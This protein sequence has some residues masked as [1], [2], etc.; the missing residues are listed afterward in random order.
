[1]IFRVIRRKLDKAL[2]YFTSRFILAVIK[3][4]DSFHISVVQLFICR[5]RRL[6]LLISF[7]A[8]IGFGQNSNSRN[9]AVPASGLSVH[10]LE[11][12]GS[13][14]HHIV[15]LLCSVFYL[16]SDFIYSKTEL[17]RE[18]HHCHIK[19]C[20]IDEIA[21]CVIQKF[22]RSIAQLYRTAARVEQPVGSEPFAALEFFGILV[23]EI[24][25]AFVVP[26]I[27]HEY[28][29]ILFEYVAERL[30]PLLG[31]L[32]YGRLV[33]LGIHQQIV[34][35]LDYRGTLSRRG[36]VVRHRLMPYDEGELV[37]IVIYSILYEMIEIG[38]YDNIVFRLAHY[39]RKRDIAHRGAFIHHNLLK[40]FVALARLLVS[41][42]IIVA[43]IAV[44]VLLGDALVGFPPLKL[45]ITAAFRYLLFPSV[46]KLL[47]GWYPR[48]YGRARAYNKAK[49]LVAVGSLRHIYIIHKRTYPDYL[50]ILFSFSSFHC[51]LP[52]YKDSP[53]LYIISHAL[54]SPE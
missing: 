43:V 26:G 48:R 15:L 52:Q 44:L 34:M 37:L 4:H 16:L 19:V 5:N 35:Y 33:I 30:P 3:I 32:I 12:L 29:M 22:V 27:A 7:F 10:L 47:P 51:R 1:M 18:E 39:M 17:V 8:R 14:S 54:S 40:E 23:E 50:I 6:A 31:K 2:K 53:I 38:G 28:G 20:V 11:L 21:P 41:F 45:I 24:H 36:Y 25:E 9:I 13:L 49:A 46:Y 42:L